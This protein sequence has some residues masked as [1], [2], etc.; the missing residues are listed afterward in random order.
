MNKFK[1]VGG[2]DSCCKKNVCNIKEIREGV[3]KVINN[4]VYNTSEILEFSSSCKEWDN[5]IR[6][7]GLL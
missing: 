7:K 1:I 4:E 5:G 3:L 2:C 6:E